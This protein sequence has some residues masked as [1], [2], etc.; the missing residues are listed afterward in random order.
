[1]I[2]KYIIQFGLS[3]NV[4]LIIFLMLGCEDK[5]LDGM[6]DDQ[7]Y[8]VE[9]GLVH[10]DTMYNNR[11]HEDVEIPVYK[12][13]YGQETATVI[14]EEDQAALE[15]YNLQNGTK[16]MML[17][18]HTYTIAKNTYSFAAK[19]YRGFVT[20]KFD[21]NA[22]IDL[23][24]SDDFDY[25]VPL[26]V[27]TV[28]GVRINEKLD[29]I[30]VA[31]IAVRA[32]LSF[33]T[34]GDKGMNE[35][36]SANDALQEQEFKV[37]VGTNCDNADD[38]SFAL[39]IDQDILTSFDLSGA[40]LAPDDSYVLD[41][42]EYTLPQG[43]NEREIS[44]KIKTEKFFKN[45]SWLFGD[46]VIPLRISKVSKYHLDPIKSIRLFKF[47]IMAPEIDRSIWAILDWNSSII[48][49]PQY[50]GLERGPDKVLDGDQN[51]FW[52]S[53]WD[54]PK[55]FPYYFTFDM[56]KEYKLTKF[57]LFKPL[58]NNAAWRGLFKKGYLEVSL[59]NSIWHKAM[60]WEVVSN[61]PREEYF[62]VPLTKA[63]YVRLVITEAF[64]YADGGLNPA[65]GARLDLAE[66]KVWG[67]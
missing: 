7:V 12:S 47:K 39:D 41:A 66:F 53:K 49:E 54:E 4:A 51:T 17:P 57:A 27:S 64:E 13:G 37:K 34:Y 1:M 9:T 48:E 31:P 21:V 60:D 52:G 65:S 18:K 8:L 55:P 22:L 40:L 43:V 58:G 28:S 20:I 23:G 45:G 44:I 25:V 32:T 3:I 38:L 36:V 15:A 42:Q 19:D 24:D 59:D 14:L 46:Y 29:F 2:K 5:R 35:E 33:N 63:R 26:K 56:K 61:A 10:P 67:Y 16:Y 6:V 11:S 62:N 30:L 50:A